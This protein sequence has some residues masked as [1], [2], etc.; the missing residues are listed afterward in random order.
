MSEAKWVKD[1]M[2]PLD[3]YALV[4]E[5]ASMVDAYRALEDA[6][7]KLPPGR[8]PSRAVLVVDHNGKIIGKV[9]QLAF[10]KALEPKY[11]KVGDLGALARAGLSDDFIDSMIG[12]LQLWQESFFDICQRARITRVKHIMHPVEESVDEDAPLREAVHKIIMYQTLS[13]LVKRGNQIV[14]I[15]RL[16]DLFVEIGKQIDTCSDSH[17]EL[18]I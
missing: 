15:L 1:V 10:L 3:D 5:D 13:L 6:Q 8:Q 4:P 11:D 2:L 17:S 7:K 18:A 16:S 9:G 12:N 14:G